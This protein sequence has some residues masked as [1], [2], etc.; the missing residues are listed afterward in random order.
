M[1][2][3]DRRCRCRSRAGMTGRQVP[4]GLGTGRGMASADRRSS[5]RRPAPRALAALVPA[6]WALFFRVLLILVFLGRMMLAAGGRRR[7]AEAL[8][9][10]RMR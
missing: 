7:A 1:A 10:G 5:L 3:C 4:A 8:W 2:N 6:F 9:C